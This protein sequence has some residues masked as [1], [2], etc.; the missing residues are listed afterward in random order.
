LPEQSVGGTAAATDEACGPLPVLNRAVLD[1]LGRTLDSCAAA[2]RFAAEFHAMLNGRV[3]RILRALQLPDPDEAMDAV[4]SLR[5]SSH[6][7][8]A[9]AME[10]QCA[11]LQ[12]QLEAG[13]LV[14]PSRSAALEA[15]RDELSA[16]LAALA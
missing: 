16:A 8:G 3:Q 2:S 1:E 14:E 4:L 13:H 12:H 11:N 10:D 9:A 15:S 6:M 5:I 7:V